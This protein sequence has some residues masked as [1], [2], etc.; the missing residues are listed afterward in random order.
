MSRRSSRSERPS[1]PRRTQA[2]ALE[3]RA[4]ELATQREHHEQPER[5][6]TADLDTLRGHLHTM[7]NDSDRKRVKGGYPKP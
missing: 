3:R 5:V 1:R 4:G 2:K 6:C 7:L